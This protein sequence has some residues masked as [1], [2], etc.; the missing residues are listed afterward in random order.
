VSIKRLI[1]ASAA[2]AALA[3]GSVAAIAAT[4]SD[5]AKKTED[6]I[7]ADAAQRLNVSPD[8]LRDALSKAEDT[9]LDQA[10]K[11]GRL[12]Q[13][14]AD[15]IKKERD[16]EGRVLGIPPGDHHGF[17]GHLFM[18]PGGPG[19]GRGGPP[20]F[21]P[22]FDFGI[23]PMSNVAKALGISSSELFKELR[24]G[25][26]LSAIAKAHG[27]S[28]KEVEKSVKAAIAKSLDKAVKDGKLTDK[29]RD[30]ILKHFSVHLGHLG[31]LKFGMR[32][33][34]RPPHFRGGPPPFMP[35]GGE[36]GTSAAPEPAP[37]P[38]I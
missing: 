5:D 38:Q 11:D 24:S 18:G 8:Q 20:G 17:R 28:L 10:V 21:G 16:R 30:E 29:Q 34:G 33:H 6:A 12:T 23:D 14:Q 2:I 19:F 27:K 1:I 35:G 32:F 7:L 15:A 26:S 9:Q 25:K 31:G 36:P 13:K 22:G 3:G 4:K 37:T